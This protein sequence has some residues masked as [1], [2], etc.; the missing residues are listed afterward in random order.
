ML[1]RDMFFIG[2]ALF[3]EGVA[4][5]ERYEDHCLSFTDATTIALVEH[6]DF[7]YVLSFDDF[8]GLVSRLDPTD[9]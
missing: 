3:F 9:L 8:D 6:H 1:F 5:R 7:D 2:R 4:V